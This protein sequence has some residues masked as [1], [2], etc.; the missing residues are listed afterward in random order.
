M[1]A[2]LVPEGMRFMSLGFPRWLWVGITAVWVPALVVACGGRGP[3]DTTIAAYDS[4]NIELPGV[5]AGAGEKDAGKDAGKDASKDGSTPVAD[6][7]KDAGGF[8]LPPIP[9]LTGDAGIGA[10]ISCAQQHCNTQ[11]SACFS[12]PAC[13]Q[14]GFCDLMTC[15]AGG[16]M[17]GSST[18]GGAGGL[19]SVDFE[20]FSTCATNQT[21]NQD[22]TAAL[23]CVFASCA[24]DCLSALG[25]LGGTGGGGLG[26]LGGLGGGLGGLGGLGGTQAP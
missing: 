13:V 24:S 8:M 17:G 2:R 14:E 1:W 6:A 18:G 5:D 19:G 15:L 9:G 11:G 4:P 12:D 21:A 16:T 3:L 22:L 25:S 10:C 7:G 23:T 20:C 26:G